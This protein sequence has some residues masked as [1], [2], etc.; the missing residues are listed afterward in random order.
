MMMR[1]SISVGLGLLCLAGCGV[2]SGDSEDL[3]MRLW[4]CSQCV[5]EEVEWELEPIDP[6]PV[7]DFTDIVYENVQNHLAEYPEFTDANVPYKVT[8]NFYIRTECDPGAKYLVLISNG[9]QGTAALNDGN[10]SRAIGLEKNWRKDACNSVSD[11]VLSPSEHGLMRRLV[12]GNFLPME[13]TCRVYIADNG[14]RWDF[15]ETNRASIVVALADYLDTL[16]DESQLE[17]AF[18]G[19]SSRGAAVTMGTM[20][21]LFENRPGDP[22]VPGSGWSAVPTVMAFNDAVIRGNDRNITR[23]STKVENPILKEH[24]NSQNDRWYTID[25]LAEL[26]E[27]AKLGNARIFNVVGGD[28]IM[29]GSQAR[30]SGSSRF[31]SAQDL[32]GWDEPI[33]VFAEECSGASAP[34]YAQ[35]NVR[36]PL[37][38]S[39]LNGTLR[40]TEADKPGTWTGNYIV[41]PGQIYDTMALDFLAAALVDHGVRPEGYEF[42]DGKGQ[43]ISPRAVPLVHM[44]DWSVIPGQSDFIDGSTIVQSVQCNPPAGPSCEDQCMDEVG[45]CAQEFCMMSYD[46]FM[47]E[48]GCDMLF[49]MCM[50]NC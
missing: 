7:L 35:V 45:A 8:K 47:C 15:S 33:E 31:A 11:C 24:W 38:H 19:A 30:S 34:Y 14:S 23:G 27:P 2:E 22:E 21:E 28:Q 6:A 5:V 39:G 44:A 3:E 36:Y 16:I 20:L 42:E 17:F 18:V 37:T 32:E 10:E 48:T 50:G 49:G 29:L 12:E 4:D 41:N 1:R 40:T 25:F 46:P 26:G 13:D 43:E 9:Q